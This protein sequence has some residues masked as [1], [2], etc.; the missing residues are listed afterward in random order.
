M[1]APLKALATAAAADILWAVLAA[2]GA[3]ANGAWAAAI[4][5]FLILWKL[6]DKIDRLESRNETLRRRVRRIQ[7]RKD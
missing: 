2:S 5:Y 6:Y 3:G 1:S 7:P 4:I